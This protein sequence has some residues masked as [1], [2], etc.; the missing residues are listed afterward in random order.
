MN[1]FRL[2]KLSDNVMRLVISNHGCMNGYNTQKGFTSWN[3]VQ[4][5]FDLKFSSKESDDILVCGVTQEDMHGSPGGTL[6]GFG[7]VH[8]NEVALPDQSTGPLGVVCGVRNLMYSSQ[9][10]HMY[11]KGIMRNHIFNSNVKDKFGSLMEY[12][13][14][15]TGY[16]G[17]RRQLTQK[18]QELCSFFNRRTPVNTGPRRYQRNIS[19]DSKVKDI[20]GVDMSQSNMA[21]FISNL[22]NRA[23]SPAYDIVGADRCVGFGVAYLMSYRNVSNIM[24]NSMDYRSNTLMNS[25]LSQSISRIH[26]IVDSIRIKD[27]DKIDELFC[28]GLLGHHGSDSEIFAHAGDISQS[29]G[30]VHGFFA[31]EKYFTQQTIE[32]ADCYN[33]GY[34]SSTLQSNLAKE[35][36][37]FSLE[38]PCVP[39]NSV[40]FSG[41]LQAPIAI[42]V[43]SISDTLTRTT[44]KEYII[45]N[46]R[47]I[48]VYRKLTKFLPAAMNKISEIGI[49][50]TQKERLIKTSKTFSQWVS[51]ESA[52]YQTRPSDGFDVAIMDDNYEEQDIA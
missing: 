41:F 32:G 17:V 33:K 48:G 11:R 16:S 50:T 9:I 14:V 31:L 27:R 42:D 21:R 40:S 49:N 47:I 2:F 35:Y 51:T 3:G 20:L 10:N 7:W 23:S 8:S 30:V 25:V 1:T 4:F 13:D 15:L 45:D 46:D 37:G 43:F 5:T 28:M 22:V 36:P 26:E 44:K 19:F 29:I 6:L 12:G 38:E 52:I 24:I 18:E 39:V 34:Q